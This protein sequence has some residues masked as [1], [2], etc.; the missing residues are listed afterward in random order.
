MV[1][2]TRPF[3]QQKKPEMSNIA[4]ILQEHWGARHLIPRGAWLVLL[5]YS[6]VAFGS[7][8]PPKTTWLEIVMG[9]GLLMGG[10][11]LAGLVIREAR[12]QRSARWCLILAALL[13]FIPLCVG[14]M[15][16]NAWSDMARDIFPLAFLVLIP[17]VL[18]YS[19]L[20]DNRAILRTLMITV[21]V[22]V[23]ICTAVTFF[24]GAFKLTGST[25]Q[26][27]LMMRGGLGQI[28]PPKISLAG[29]DEQ[30][31]IV[32]L[33]IYDPAML[34]AAIFLSAWGTILMVKSWWGW[35]PGLVLAGIGALIAYGF[36]ILGL[37]A[38]A[39]FFV[40]AVLSVS[41]TKWRERGLYIRLFPVFIVACIA[42]WSQIEAVLQ[43]LWI[44]QQVTGTN[45]KAGE[46]LAVI[47]SVF[48][49]PQ[50]VL[51]GIGWGGK[52]NNPILH[53]TTRFTHSAL[54]F[55]L[56]KSGVLGLTTLLSIIGILFFQGRRLGESG[57]LTT[58]RLILLASCLPP[59]VIGVLFEPT[60]KMLSYGVILALF[61]LVLPSFG[62]RAW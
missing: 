51:F 53:E 13:F 26:M 44:K 59:L 10:I 36:M 23:G 1:F 29:L 4:A 43:L 62:K 33:K 16:G 37:R 15:R 49:T 17:I 56:L 31:R 30:V 2:T 20:S 34:F 50:S 21:L 45:G 9:C 42:F 57:E 41:L 14:L 38:Y 54:S 27:V 58:S 28:M 35:L 11:S 8:M 6:L 39:A 61:V 60:Y 19:S 3:K 5:A 55:Y 40:L 47:N 24:V 46:W 25:D 48:S 7:P 12:Q 32:F 52:F 22:F 18:I